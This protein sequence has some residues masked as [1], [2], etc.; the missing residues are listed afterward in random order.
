M[1]WIQGCSSLSRWLV[2]WHKYISDDWPTGDA[3]PAEGSGNSLGK[4]YVHGV[5]DGFSLYCLFSRWKLL[6]TLHLISIVGGIW[7]SPIHHIGYYWHLFCNP[8]TF[9][10]R[11]CWCEV[12]RNSRRCRNI[13]KV[14]IIRLYKIKFKRCFFNLEMTD[15]SGCLCVALRQD[16]R[17]NKILKKLE[18]QQTM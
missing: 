2:C 18:A 1:P 6:L 11:D 10:P 13:W 3:N 16:T 5:S 4:C 8:W 15:F 14:S 7:K 12:S 17:S 9:P